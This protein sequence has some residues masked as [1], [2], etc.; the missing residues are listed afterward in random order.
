MCAGTRTYE[1]GA[2]LVDNEINELAMWCNESDWNSWRATRRRES[3]AVGRIPAPWRLAVVVGIL[4]R[5]PCC[6]LVVPSFPRAGPVGLGASLMD[7][8]GP[9][10]G[11]VHP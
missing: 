1:R 11:P 2:V 3:K 10:S 9:Q 6:I 8:T 4:L 7:V 5:T